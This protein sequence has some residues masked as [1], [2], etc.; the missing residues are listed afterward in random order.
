ML[1]GLGRGSGPRSI[2]GM[3]AWEA[4]WYRRPFLG[5]RRA[6]TGAACDALGLTPGTTRTTSTPATAAS[7]CATRC[8]RCS[9]TSSAAEWP[10][11]S[12]APPTCSRDVDALDEQAT[13]AFH[14]LVT[15]G[16]AEPPSLPVGPAAELPPALRTRVLRLWAAAVGADPLTAE[17]VHALDALLTGWHGQGPVPLPGGFEASRASGRIEAHPRREE[18]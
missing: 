17:H 6:T 10:R 9:T 2:A 3:R 4:T 1:L 8:C 11:R 14:D 15:P 13:A 7:G 16:V 5:L 12:P 18:A